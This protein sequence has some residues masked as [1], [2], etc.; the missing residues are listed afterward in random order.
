MLLTHCCVSFTWETFRCREIPSPSLDHFYSL[1]SLPTRGRGGVFVFWGLFRTSDSKERS[2]AVLSDFSDAHTPAAALLHLLSGALVRGLQNTHTL[3]MPTRLSTGFSLCP[4]SK[5]TC[6]LARGG[7]SSCLS[8]PCLSLL[9]PPSPALL[10]S[11]C[12]RWTPIVLC[13]SL[14]LSSAGHVA[15]VMVHFS[16]PRD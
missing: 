11:P 8:A 4:P 13:L 9:F 3:H 15:W 7:G 12:R 6:S 1:F 10:A 16:H 14:S 2:C 5:F